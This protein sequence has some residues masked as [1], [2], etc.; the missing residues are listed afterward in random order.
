MPILLVESGKNRGEAFVLPPEGAATAGRE[1]SCELRVPD[2]MASRRHFEVRAAG[3]G[4][5][6]RDLKSS[7]GTFL[8][9]ARLPPDE[10]RPIQ[11]EDKI[12]LG[13]T[14]I[15]LVPD[16]A[17]ESR[18]E[19]TGRTVGG[20][21]IEERLGRGAMGTV[22]KAVQLSL[23]RPV[24]LKI[25]A[26]ELASDRKRVDMFL[27]EAR[28][29]GKLNHPNLV[30]VYDVGSE[31]DL[32][33][34]SMEYMTG[35]SVEE[36]IHREGRLST[37][38]ALRVAIDAAKGLEYAERE[39]IVHRDVK[40]ANLMVNAEGVTKI[41]DL[42]IA[43][44]AGVGEQGDGIAGSPL[45]M[46]PEQARGEPLDGR[47]DLYALGATLHHA[48]AGEPPFQG[49]S[50]REVI[51][52]HFDAAPPDL[53][54]IDPAIPEDL[55]RLVGRL[56]AKSRD[57]RPAGAT[58]L[59]DELR[60]VAGGLEARA[61]GERRRALWP[62]GVAAALFVLLLARGILV[63]IRDRQTRERAR[64]EAREKADA[65][66][67]ALRKLAQEAAARR[68]RE[69]A[70][71]ARQAR[72]L[73][74]EQAFEAADAY[75]G[76]HGDDLDGVL[77]RYRE[78]LKTCPGTPAEAR[79]RARIEQVAP[80]AESALGQKKEQEAREARARDALRA[81]ADAIDA[82]P[83]E[84]LLAL[85]E[86]LEALRPSLEGTEAAKQAADV[87]RAITAKVARSL[88]SAEEEAKSALQKPDYPAARA[89]VDRVASW[90]MTELRPWVDGQ[91]QVIEA[92]EHRAKASAAE[93]KSAQLQAELAL[94]RAADERERLRD[95]RYAEA[96]AALEA[97]LPRLATEEGHGLAEARIATIALEEKALRA[98]AAYVKER[99]KPA[100]ASAVAGFDGVAVSADEGGITFQARDNA[101][102]E[103]RAGFG[104]L[105]A[106]DWQRFLGAVAAASA[107]RDEIEFALAAILADLGDEEHA[108][109]ELERI[110][111]PGPAVKPL[112]ERA[113]AGK[114]R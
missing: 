78:I 13:S 9:G 33:F 102:I 70:E 77:A 17:R 105:G 15:T 19:L 93:Q 80:L 63:A 28:A 64:A 25:L 50:P 111:A 69:D 57:E 79:A 37:R 73:A 92:E 76:E 1:K 84:G 5:T 38:E 29:A 96:R 51:L 74:A 114:G 94:V 112:L 108:R 103:A 91:R 12:Q 4:F 98:L 2:V 113:L 30:Q 21:R 53:H 100:L 99:R 42:G 95:C 47:A 55:A 110:K 32:Y 86:K 40:P 65:A 48:L 41:G 87:R 72:E 75:L 106:A 20:Y 14:L 7:N 10:P 45:Y 104:R 54:A 107:P 26:R 101:G 83:P 60:A 8:N 11:F 35:G 62:I 43:R 31:G 18:G 6:I 49:S 34:F 82:T 61:P 27:Q 88:A 3:G 24:A 39:G 52:Q 56:L 89:A 85:R 44:P 109:R 23:E 59:L 71:S 97:L 58:A 68:A 81:I 67:A 22:Y 16:E 90:N 46:A 66:S 36:K